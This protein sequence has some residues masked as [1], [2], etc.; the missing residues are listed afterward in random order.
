MFGNLSQMAGML[1]KA[2]E[3]QGNIKKMRS[4]MEQARYEASAGAGD[5][6]SATVS[7]DFRLVALNIRPEAAANPDLS[8]LV[9]D[10]V[11]AALDTAKASAQQSL[12]DATGGL[13]IPGLF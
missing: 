9:T 4:E 11:N 7:G 1:K 13:D 8:K 5:L 10:A 12:K 6:V 3:I 2:Q